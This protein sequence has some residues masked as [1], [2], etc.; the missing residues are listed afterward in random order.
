MSILVGGGAANDVPLK[1]GEGMGSKEEAPSSSTLG[2]LGQFA[3]NIIGQGPASG[4]SFSTYARLQAGAKSTPSSAVDKG[5]RK[6]KDTNVEGAQTPHLPHH[7]K[8]EGDQMPA[9]QNDAGLPSKGGKTP[10]D[11]KTTDGTATTK[12]SANEG[13]GPS[14]DARPTGTQDTPGSR[15]VDPATNTH[16]PSFAPHTG[17]QATY[18]HVVN[19]PEPDSHKSKYVYAEATSDGAIPSGKAP[20]SSTSRDAYNPVTTGD[21]LKNE[22]GIGSS[23]KMHRNNQDEAGE[24]VEE[25]IGRAPGQ[26]GDDVGGR[27][28]K[29]APPP[30]VGEIEED[31][32]ELLLSTCLRHVRCRTCSC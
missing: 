7:Q 20:R 26:A 10:S 27:G 4:K 13:K 1:E 18:S 16:S 6:P 31:T 5:A 24:M 3:K 29:F 11:K 9:V 25:M 21:I 8:G 23:N 14:H 15:A 30:D 32:R 22:A 17:A 19:S 28:R 12:A 2:G